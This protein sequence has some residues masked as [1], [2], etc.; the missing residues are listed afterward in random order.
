MANLQ[1]RKRHSANQV[2]WRSVKV[3]PASEPNKT[4]R[5][6]RSALASGRS[7]ARSSLWIQKTRGRRLCLGIRPFSTPKPAIGF[8]RGSLHETLEATHSTQTPWP[9]YRVR[10]GN[11]RRDFLPAQIAIGFVLENCVIA[12]GGRRACPKADKRSSACVLSK[13]IAGDT[14]SLCSRVAPCLVHNASRRNADGLSP[15]HESRPLFRYDRER[16][17]LRPSKIIGRVERRGSKG[18]GGRASSG[19]QPGKALRLP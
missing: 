10:S 18:F 3:D 17:G 5:R 15:C 6:V 1:S 9:M 13:S 12:S 11:S 4:E 19:C 8:V 16:F 14:A 2:R 7:S